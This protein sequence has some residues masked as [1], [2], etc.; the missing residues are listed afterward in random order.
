MARVGSINHQ[1]GKIIKAH[2]GIG[3][4]KLESRNSSGLVSAESGHKV[5]DKFHSY[6]S[7]DNARNDLK[8]LGNYAKEE[9]GIKDMSQINRE[10]VENW[11][12]DKDITYNTASNYLSEINKVH[13]HLNITREEV[14][15][16]RAELK[17]ELRTNELQSRA[18]SNLDRIQLPERSQPAFELQRDYGLRVSAATHINIEKQLNDENILSYQEKGGKW[19]EKE[20]S[21]TLASKIR[22]NA[23]E[24]KYEL[25]RDTYRDQLQK[26]IEK[27]GQEYNGTHGIR[28]SYAQKELELGKSKQEVSESMGHSREEITNTYLR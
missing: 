11:I 4:S 28:H 13:E 21:D 1:V 26:E 10:V 17:T 8:N 2:N 7:L 3:Q 18:Y 12:R 14:K 15:E 23:V 25:S 16:L 27:S 9:F 24:G 22:E 5:S 6:K 19:S 20:L